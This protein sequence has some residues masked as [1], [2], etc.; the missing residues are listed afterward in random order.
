MVQEELDV[1]RAC[2]ERGSP[3]ER[4]LSYAV[5][6]VQ[7]KVGT[8]SDADGSLVTV[9]RAAK[10]GEYVFCQSQG[11]ATRMPTAATRSPPATPGRA[12]RCKRR[13]ALRR[14]CACTTPRVRANGWRSR[15]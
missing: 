12:R 6:P 3:A 11:A 8:Q 9:A 2:P 13:S 4:D 14:I 15:R 7:L 5:D 1:A 10:T